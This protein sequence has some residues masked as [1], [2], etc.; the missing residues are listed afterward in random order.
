MLLLS[1]TS[2]VLVPTQQ[3]AIGFQVSAPGEKK[4]GNSA[5][6]QLSSLA[7]MLHR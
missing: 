2:E 1:V 6:Q 7:V 4:R 5:A 3:Q